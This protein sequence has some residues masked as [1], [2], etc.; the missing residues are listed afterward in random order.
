[1]DVWGVSKKYFCKYIGSNILE[2]IYSKK[3]C[4]ILG[5]QSEYDSNILKVKSIY[6]WENDLIKLS[7]WIFI[8]NSLLIHQW[9]MSYHDTCIHCLYISLSTSFSLLKFF[10]PIP[11]QVSSKSRPYDHIISAYY[12]ASKLMP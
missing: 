7:V 5:E 6:W 8:F 10:L 1:M 2:V 11:T 9:T 3:I 12:L 4:S